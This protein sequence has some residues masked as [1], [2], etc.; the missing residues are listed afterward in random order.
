MAACISAT[1]KPDL[2]LIDDDNPEW[3]A[4]DFAR[5]RSGAEV[6]PPEFVRKIRGEPAPEP[7]T[8]TLH[9]NDKED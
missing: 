4:E 6:L 8:D 1:K 9:P 2:E 5:A 3:T 7:P